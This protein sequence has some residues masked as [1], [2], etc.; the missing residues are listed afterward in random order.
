MARVVMTLRV[1]YRPAFDALL[2][3]AHEIRATHGDECAAAWASAALEADF[4]LFCRIVSDTRPVLRL[5]Q[6]GRC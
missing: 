4:D 5:I 6:G 1:E 2:A 3:C